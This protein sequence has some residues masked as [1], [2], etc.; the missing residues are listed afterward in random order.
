MYLLNA[1]SFKFYERICIL[2]QGSSVLKWNFI[3]DFDLSLIEKLRIVAKITQL[4]YVNFDRSLPEKLRCVAKIAQQRKVTPHESFTFRGL[5]I[6][7]VEEQWCARDGA[8]PEEARRA[9][10]L[11]YVQE[12]RPPHCPPFH[13]APPALCSPWP[14]WTPPRNSGIMLTKLPVECSGQFVEKSLTNQSRKFQSLYGGEESFQEQSGI[15]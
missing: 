9:S 1:F 8:E 3:A 15:E 7:L 6:L 14:L 10:G 4:F 13:R 12:S 11:G 5:K 2:H